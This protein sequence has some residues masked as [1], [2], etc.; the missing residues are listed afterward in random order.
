MTP[1]VW[2]PRDLHSG[3]ER[4]VSS[5]DD[6]QGGVNSCEC[7]PSYQH[8][9]TYKVNGTPWITCPSLLLAMPPSYRAKTA[10]GE[11]GLDAR[12]ASGLGT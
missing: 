6:T 11:P 9:V 1:Y 12:W 7:R 5:A 10:Y 8:R 2:H 3:V 4:E